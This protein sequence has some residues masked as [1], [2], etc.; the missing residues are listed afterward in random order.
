MARTEGSAKNS[1][2]SLDASISTSPDLEKYLKNNKVYGLIKT[3]NK[4]TYELAVNTKQL[5]SVKEEDTVLGSDLV[6]LLNSIRKEYKDNPDFSKIATH[7]VEADTEYN[8]SKGKIIVN[9]VL[10]K[11]RKI[12]EII[13]LPTKLDKVKLEKLVKPFG[14][15]KI[16]WDNRWKLKESSILKGVYDDEILTSN[17]YHTGRTGTLTTNLRTL[18]SK[19]KDRRDREAARRC[20]GLKGSLFEIGTNFVGQIRL[21]SPFTYHSHN[22]TLKWQSENSIKW[23]ILFYSTRYQT[24]LNKIC[25]K[26]LP[27]LE[28]ILSKANLDKA[29][30]HK[31]RRVFS[32]ITAF[33]NKIRKRTMESN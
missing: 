17:L 28:F 31:E 15:V 21:Y 27:K 16:P 25:N 9:R 33:T 20:L 1:L 8:Y 29:R 32:A 18:N 22:K 23:K 3:S 12:P 19:K 4:D 2:Y 7:K 24:Q 10:I 26:V 14:T 11:K 6:D 5:A 13:N 30:N